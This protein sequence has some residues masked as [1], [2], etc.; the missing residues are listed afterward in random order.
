MSLWPDPVDCS[1]PGITRRR[2]LWSADFPL[3]LALSA[4]GSDRPASLGISIYHKKIGD[5]ADFFMVYATSS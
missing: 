1:T 3:P 5:P 2:A 4:S